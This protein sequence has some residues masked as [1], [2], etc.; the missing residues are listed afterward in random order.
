[1]LTVIAI[2]ESVNISVMSLVKEIL[3][4]TAKHYPLGYKGLYEHLYGETVYGKKLNKRSLSAIVS[5]MKK[6]G[7]L[8]TKGNG[9]ML[10]ESGKNRLEKDTGAMKKF[11]GDESYV[12]NKNTKKNLII[13]FDIPERKRL[14]REWLRI[15]LVGFGYTMIQKSVWF[16]PPLPEEFIE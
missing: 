15:E 4:T 6:N 7:L 10:T 2:A 3:R 14:Y 5:R 9:L 1:M 11:A 13:V 12:V 16:G 8:K